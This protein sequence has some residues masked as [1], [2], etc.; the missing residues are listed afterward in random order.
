VSIVTY[1]F[2]FD[3]FARSSAADEA[4]TRSKHLKYPVPGAPTVYLAFEEE[5]YAL[6]GPVSDALAGCGVSLHC[7]WSAGQLFERLSEKGARELETKLSFPDV[8]FVALVSER[9]RHIERITWSLDLARQTLPAGRYAYLPVRYESTDWDP[10]TAL[11]GYP[12]IEAR[13]NDL[14]RIM[15]DST[16]QL[17][18]GRWFQH[19]A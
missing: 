10:P 9:A 11:R 3:R 1:A 13:R 8:W 5:D 16:Y 19:S 14:V 4:G 6:T 2:L 15:P 7:D 12:R 17:P 18:L